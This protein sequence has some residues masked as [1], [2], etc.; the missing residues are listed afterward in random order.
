MSVRAQEQDDWQKFLQIVYDEIWIVSFEK[1]KKSSSVKMINNISHINSS[2]I[3]SK[4]DNIRLLYCVIHGRCMHTTGKCNKFKNYINKFK[5]KNDKKKVV[6]KNNSN[7]IRRIKK[8][9]VKIKQS[10]TNDNNDTFTTQANVM[11]K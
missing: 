8:S 9:I 7:K 3:P 2:I 4:K 1:P 5:N 10:I 11:A 6:K